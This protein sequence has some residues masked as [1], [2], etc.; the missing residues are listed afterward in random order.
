MKLHS[1]Y[2]RKGCVLPDRLDPLQDP[3]GDKWALVEEIPALVF[4]TMIRQ[5]GW[6]FIWIKGLCSR[7]GFGITQETAA[8]RA[9]GRALAGVGRRCNAAEL[10]FFHVA[11]YLGFYVAIVTLELRQIQQYTA[12]ELA[13]EMQASA[14]PAG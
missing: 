1:V 2:L 6:H 5:A 14:T 4:E 12:L 10:N 11:R 8:N 3:I 13:G 7:I 9:L